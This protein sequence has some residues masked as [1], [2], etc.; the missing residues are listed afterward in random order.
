MGEDMAAE[1]TTAPV[2]LLLIEDNDIDQEI[3]RRAFRSADIPCELLVARD[4][5]EAIDIMLGD[6]G[7]EPLGRP[8]LVMLDLDMPGVDGLEFLSEIR[9]DPILRRTVIFILTGAIR[10]QD[11]DR[12]YDHCVAGVLLKD[13]LS[14]D[15]IPLV[16]ML[17]DYWTLVDFPRE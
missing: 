10:D 1:T 9:A 2:K 8:Y 12:C 3:V 16:S 4:G 17:N 11:R 14:S 7:N 15:P 13:R 6:S 5:G